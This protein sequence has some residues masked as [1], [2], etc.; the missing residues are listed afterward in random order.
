[1]WQSFVNIGQDIF[2]SKKKKKLKFNNMS[3][4]YIHGRD[5]EKLNI[6]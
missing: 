2:F 4:S 6:S 1:M 5:P 3:T